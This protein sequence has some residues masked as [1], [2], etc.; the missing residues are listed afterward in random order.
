M[1]Y[2]VKINA[3]DLDVDSG[4]GILL[5]I[6][7]PTGRI[8]NISYTTMDQAKTNLKNLILTNTGERIMQP[9]FGCDIRKLLF[10]QITPEL[11]IELINRIKSKIKFWLPYITVN[12][13]DIRLLYD[14]NQIEFSIDFGLFDNKFD[15]ENI[16]FKVDLP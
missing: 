11:R 10:E 9:E 3:L 5:D 14:F 6:T 2:E 16:T 8:F 1:A 15:T 12:G 4:I 7:S 13:L